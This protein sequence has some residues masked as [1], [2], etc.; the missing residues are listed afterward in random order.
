M[1]EECP[2]CKRMLLLGDSYVSKQGEKG[3]PARL[4][5]RR[6][7]KL[8]PRCTSKMCKKSNKRHCDLFQETTRS[9]IFEEF[10]AL[11]WEA[12]YIFVVSGWMLT[13]LKR[14]NLEIPKVKTLIIIWRRLH[15]GGET[16]ARRIGML[17]EGYELRQRAIRDS[18]TT[19]MNVSNRCRRPSSR[20]AEA[21][22]P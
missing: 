1:E 10:W 9:V 5:K 7:K 15:H 18:I 19:L 21:C 14:G 8:G 12:Q 17:N 2:K 16:G 3:C 20:S 13:K 22:C 4:T 6:E 11:P